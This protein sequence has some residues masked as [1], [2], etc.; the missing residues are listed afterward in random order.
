MALLGM[1]GNPESTLRDSL[2]AGT[3]PSTAALVFALL[4]LGPLQWAHQAPEEGQGPLQETRG[5]NRSNSFPG[6]PQVIRL[7]QPTYETQA[8]VGMTLVYVRRRLQARF[9]VKLLSFQ[10]RFMQSAMPL[11]A[12][13]EDTQINPSARKTRFRSIVGDPTCVV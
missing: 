7:P 12:T 2:G 3:I 6:T 9:V 10:C 5:N 1:N 8:K 13:W 4:Q 11:R